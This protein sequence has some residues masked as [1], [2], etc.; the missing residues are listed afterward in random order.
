V[1]WVKR[2]WIWFGASFQIGVSTSTSR[3]LYD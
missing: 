2:A 3:E 1:G